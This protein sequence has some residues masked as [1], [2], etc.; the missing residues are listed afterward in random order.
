[1]GN[2]FLIIALLMATN[3]QWF[4]LQSIA[5]ASMIVRYSEKAPLEVALMHTF[6]GKHPCCMCKA[7]A[8]ARKSEQKKGFTVQIKKLEFPPAPENFVL[9]APSRFQL[10]PQE[11]SFADSLTQKPLLPPPRGFFV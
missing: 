4:V 1:V 6:D 2:C 8:A 3:S 5:W 10:L 9:V 11:N 7:I